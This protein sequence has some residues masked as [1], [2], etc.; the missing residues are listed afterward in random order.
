[1]TE[2]NAGPTVLLLEDDLFLLDMYSMKFTQAGFTVE[3]CQSTA[4]ALTSL[5]GHLQPVA[6]LFDIVMPGDD[7]FS[8]LVNK[9]IARMERSYFHPPAMI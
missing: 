7:G 4:E 1:M 6:V 8:F 5:R 2:Q 9:F 3:S